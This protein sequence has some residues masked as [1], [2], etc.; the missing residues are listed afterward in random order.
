[1]EFRVQHQ[2]RSNVIKNALKDYVSGP[3]TSKYELMNCQKKN[4]DDKTFTRK[5]AEGESIPS[6]LFSLV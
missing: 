2:L 3:P 4:M 6:L 1:M 5:F